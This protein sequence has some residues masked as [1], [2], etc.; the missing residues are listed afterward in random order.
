[1][2]ETLRAEKGGLTDRVRHSRNRLVARRHKDQE[3]HGDQAE[4]SNK[5]SAGTGGGGQQEWRIVEVDRQSKT[6]REGEESG[7]KRAV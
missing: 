4:V 6:G 7:K 3:G 1:M 5:V 2:L